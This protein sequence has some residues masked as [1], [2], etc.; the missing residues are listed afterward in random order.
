MGRLSTDLATDSLGQQ[1]TIFKEDVFPKQDTSSSSDNT[2]DKK[3]VKQTGLTTG[4][5][6]IALIGITAVCYYILHKAGSLK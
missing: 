4:Q 1:D 5:K 6:W 3:S 2:K